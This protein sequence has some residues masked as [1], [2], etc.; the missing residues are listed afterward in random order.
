MTPYC[1]LRSEA[2]LCAFAALFLVTRASPCEGTCSNATS[3]CQSLFGTPN[4]NVTA[5]RCVERDLYADLSCV[6]SAYDAG[7]NSIRLSYANVTWD[8]SYS[9]CIATNNFENAP[10]GALCTEVTGVCPTR[11]DCSSATSPFARVC[12]TQSLACRDPTQGEV[13]LGASNGMASVTGVFHCFSCDGGSYTILLDE[14]SNGSTRR[15]HKNFTKP[16]NATCVPA[17]TCNGHGCCAAVLLE[18]APSLGTCSCYQD[19]VRG[20]FDPKTACMECSAAYDSNGA[21]GKRC[22]NPKSQLVVLLLNLGISSPAAMVIPNLF[23]LVLFLIFA[24]AR[25]TWVSDDEFEMTALRRAGI[26]WNPLRDGGHTYLPL[27]REERSLFGSKELS[28]LCGGV[29]G[30]AEQPAAALSN[31]SVHFAEGPHHSVAASSSH[32]AVFK[33]KAVPRR[34]AGSQGVVSRLDSFKAEQLRKGHSV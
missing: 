22:T 19:S 16:T 28:N 4:G 12:A 33:S 29:N 8:Q 26:R 11:A 31:A 13:A 17:T 24:L 34:P 30:V 23:I 32:L 6:C 20:F 1:E 27:I 14:R 25:R 10:Q 9:T 7:L 5:E 18:S 15:C 2:I 3:V 21:D